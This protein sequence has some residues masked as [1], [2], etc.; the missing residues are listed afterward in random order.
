[1]AAVEGGR[2]KAG[3]ERREAA[4]GGRRREAAGGDGRWEAG[5][6][7]YIVGPAERKAL[8]IVCAS[9]S[10]FRLSRWWMKSVSTSIKIR[11]STLQTAS[12]SRL[13]VREAHAFM[14][15]TA[16]VSGVVNGT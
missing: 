1:M 8:S 13:P 2:R 10:R 12:Q 3:G 15:R 16:A 6:G 9:V 7:K 4:G 14:R 5:D 11:M